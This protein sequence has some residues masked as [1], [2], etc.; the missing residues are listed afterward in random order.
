[1][2]LNIYWITFRLE[3]DATYT[4]RYEK[5]NRVI[6]ELYEGGEYWDEPTSFHIL[7]SSLSIDEIA[8]TVGS[9]INKRSDL[10]LIGMPEYKASRVVGIAHDPDVFKIMP[11]CKQV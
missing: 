6:V 5:L 11:N 1:M 2:A 4:A 10:V 7:R 9:A 8:R 3:D